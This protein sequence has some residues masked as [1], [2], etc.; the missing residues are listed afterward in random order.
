MIGSLVALHLWHEILAH[1][2]RGS[3]TAV[4]RVVKPWRTARDGH[5][6]SNAQA[7]DE[8]PSARQ[9]SWWLLNLI[10]PKQ[11][12]ETA[13]I[14]ETDRRVA[15]ARQDFITELC[16]QCA[17][18]AQA[19][20]L[21][22]TFIEMLRQHSGDEP[23]EHWLDQVQHS[24]AAP[25]KGFTSGLINDKAAVMAAMRLPW[26]NGQVEG[27]VNRLK[28]IKRQMFGRASFELLRA[29]VLHPP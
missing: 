20:Q 29:R 23:F 3:L 19:Q 22:N 16:R 12:K 9:V 13:P 26:S 25:L 27:Q 6:D 4:Y 18:I 24:D 17:P 10:Q 15:Q 11:K 2:L 28:L 8:L 7:R 14:D 1:G 5:A 21:G